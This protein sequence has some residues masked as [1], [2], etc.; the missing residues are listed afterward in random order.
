MKIAFRNFLT[1]LRRYKISSLLNVIGL[2][3][4]FTAFYV[5]MTQVWWELG[6]NR[7]LHEADRIY[8]VENEDWY[9]P[10]KW[11]SWLN[12]PVP[13]RVIASTA[14]VEVGGCMWGGF[15][16]GTCWTSNEPSFG[17]NKFSASCGSVSLPFLDVFA[18]RSV[19]G[20]VHDLGKPKS[21]IVSREAAERMRVGVGSLIWVDTDEP[22]PDGAM[23]VV[24]VFEDFPDN[25]LLGECEV[26]KNLGETNLYTTSEWSFNYFVKFRPGADPDEFA[27]QWTNVNQ[28]MQREAAEKRAAAGDAADDDDESGIYGVRLSPVSELYF[29]SDSQAPCRQGSVVTTYTLLGIAVLVIVLAFINFVNFFFALVPVRIR[30]VNTFKVFGAPASSLR[31]NFVFE[32]FGLVLIA[33][34]AAWYVSFALQGTEFAS[35]ISASLALSQ[36]LEVVG[37]VAV[38]AFVMALAASLYPAWYITSFAP[39]LVVKGS[40]GGTRSGRRLRT[41]LLG[42]QFFI[43]IGLIIATS[44]IRLQHDYMMHY[45]MGFD[46]ENLLAVRLSERGAVSYDALRQKLLSDPQV[47]DVTG[48]TSRLVSVGRMGWGREFK[49]RQVAFQSYVVQP[50]FLRVMG[51]P[52]TDGRD[53]L[54]SDFDKELGTMIFNEAARREFEM[55]VGDRINGFVSP[56]EQ[57][58]GFCA[59]FN[60]KPLQYG[61]SPFCFYL[62]PKKIQQENY[63]HLPHVVYVRMTPGADIAAVTAHIRRC[64]AEVD[65]RTEPGDIVVRVFDEELGL[66][67]DNERKLTAIV[68]LFALLAVVIALMGVF[69]LVLF[70]TQ[71]RRREI[72]VRRVMG[73]S[74]GEI[75]AMFNRRYVMLVAVC[76]VLAVPVS[77]WAVRHWLA[78]FAYAV[79]L[80]WWVFALALAGV[81]AVTALTVTVRSWRAVN[82]NPAESV[83]SE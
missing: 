43:S 9:E 54:E 33:L 5:I 26:V 61:V 30:T 8:L 51:I 83:K 67:Y 16:S 34:L 71:H 76:F 60:F 64:I 13:E 79:P 46:K 7:S 37:L 40:F 39:A 48:A 21:V 38:V 22:Q 23:E 29:E 81:L 4:A 20:D 6:Y 47:K 58:V 77:I 50:D 11:S 78:G 59:D 57:I 65:P 44:F 19:E 25:S 82:E 17:Y 73:A 70:E 53:F 27:R 66:E 12:R 24:A 1:T 18:F 2:T 75:L 74:R 55:Q 32:A 56:D 62:L 63:W 49:G 69:G 10:G 45:D 80:Y 35:Y 52:I 72:A 15:G 36:N 41:L 28:E 68:G 31:F 42:V 14:G 3:L